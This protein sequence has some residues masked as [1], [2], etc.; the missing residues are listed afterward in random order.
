MQAQAKAQAG[1]GTASA[2][3][4]TGQSGA[5]SRSADA[6]QG[7]AA[8][9]TRAGL[10]AGAGAGT[11]TASAATYDGFVRGFGAPMGPLGLAG[12]QPGVSAPGTA[13]G[14]ALGPAAA[15]P[16]QP[17]A[18][19]AFNPAAPGG[20]PVDPVALRNS[21]AFW[22]KTAGPPVAPTYNGLVGS[23]GF[24]PGQAPPG[25]N[26]QSRIAQMYAPPGYGVLPG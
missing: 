5:T 17:Q 11:G 15:G 4:A 12:Y 26:H 13:W 10:G 25:F 16:P 21:N 22:A 7:G 2:A 3:F 23:G 9:T 14:G 1:A 19:Y 18:P 20:Y 8:S 6:V 24:L